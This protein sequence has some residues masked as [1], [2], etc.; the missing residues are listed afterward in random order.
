MKFFPKLFDSKKT[1][2]N[3]FKKFH[4]TTFIFTKNDRKKE[5][6]FCF[7]QEFCFFDIKIVQLSPLPKDTINM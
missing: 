5:N 3:V 4:L 2:K 1:L 7:C 6:E